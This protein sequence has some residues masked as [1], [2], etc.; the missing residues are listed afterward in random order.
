LCY[1]CAVRTASR[2]PFTDAQHAGFCDY[3]QK[4]FTAYTWLAAPKAVP[5]VFFPVIFPV[6]TTAL[7]F[8]WIGMIVVSSTLITAIFSVIA[9]IGGQLVGWVITGTQPNVSSE[10]ANNAQNMLLDLTDDYEA[11]AYYLLD[12][13]FSDTPAMRKLAAEVASALDV[14]LLEYIM[15]QLTPRLDPSEPEDPILSKARF[16]RILTP[17][18]EV[19]AYIR[20]E[21]CMPPFHE[22]LRGRLEV[23]HQRE[24]VASLAVRL[25]L[26]A[27]MLAGVPAAPKPA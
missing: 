13:H 27:S 6:V 20:S 1:L 9:V 8:L 15:L 23:A 16:R 22:G 11:L 25:D 7:Y 5:A 18:H 3:V 26:A 17:L 2:K 24:R 21:G 10:A 14:E 4:R 12:L 19:V